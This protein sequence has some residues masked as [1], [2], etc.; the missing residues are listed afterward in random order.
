MSR[1]NVDHF[2][3][4]EADDGTFAVIWEV[5]SYGSTGP[6]PGRLESEEPVIEGVS[7]E[8]AAMLQRELTK[9]NFAGVHDGVNIFTT[10]HT[11]SRQIDTLTYST[12]A[13]NF[14]EKPSLALVY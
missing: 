11:L 8:Y 5:K 3:T 14:A 13:E 12:N 4:R 1:R 6:D 9:D 2:V 7:R 10:A